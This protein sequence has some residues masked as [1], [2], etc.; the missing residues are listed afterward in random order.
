MQVVRLSILVN[1][2]TYL[3]SQAARQGHESTLD[4]LVQAGASFGGFDLESTF[5]KQAIKNALHSGDQVSFRMWNKAGLQL[6][7]FHGT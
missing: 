5:V 1:T 2:N 7:D 4:V 3:E 6:P